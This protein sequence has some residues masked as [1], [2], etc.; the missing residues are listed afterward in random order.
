MDGTREEYRKRK[1]MRGREGGRE[2]TKLVD[3]AALLLLWTRRQTL[4]GSWLVSPVQ[5]HEGRTVMMEERT[6]MRGT[7][8]REVL[9]QECGR[10]GQVN[11]TVNVSGCCSS[12]LCYYPVNTVNT[13]VNLKEHI[14]E[15][16][17][18]VSEEG[19]RGLTRQV[20]RADVEPSFSA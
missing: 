7:G 11:L 16:T 9:I 10:N 13:S 4:P 19:G 8:M 15:D 12:P 18:V 14:W 20:N 17:G 5:D 2:G 6:R 3:A 1:R